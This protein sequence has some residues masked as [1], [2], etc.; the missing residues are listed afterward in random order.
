M[1]G[2]KI[3][4]FSCNVLVINKLPKH[5]KFSKKLRPTRFFECFEIF[6][7]PL[8]V[9]LLSSSQKFRFFVI[10]KKTAPSVKFSF[11]AKISFCQI[12]KWLLAWFSNVYADIFNRLLRW[13]C[14][15][16]IHTEES[17]C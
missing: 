13:Y 15:Y 14:I 17:A 8:I 6:H 1:F 10:G 12:E 4:E 7:I 11:W 9:S 2:S 16:T 5:S 3:G